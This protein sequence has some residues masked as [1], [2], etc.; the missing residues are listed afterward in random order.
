MSF[1]P[2]C[3]GYTVIII[4]ALLGILMFF[5]LSMWLVP[6]IF[7]LIAGVLTYLKTTVFCDPTQVVDKFLDIF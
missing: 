2:L 5:V 1:N 7:L 4:I 3:P 6:A